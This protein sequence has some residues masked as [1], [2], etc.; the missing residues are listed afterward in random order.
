MRSI[1]VFALGAAA[2]V[3]GAALWSRPAVSAGPA[4]RPATRAAAPSAALAPR[5]S[6]PADLPACVDQLDAL[7]VQLAVL[8]KQLAA[9]GGARAEWPDDAPAAVRPEAVRAWLEEE[10]QGEPVSL[11]TLDCDEYPCVAV[12]RY[13]EGQPTSTEVI[14]PLHDAFEA[15]T[16]GRSP[17]ALYGAPHGAF[18]ILAATPRDLTAQAQERLTV[19]LREAGDQLTETP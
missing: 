12:F 19:R 5:L 14:G 3:L 10:M 18:A 11:E 4:S 1:L 13:A 9:Y 17:V 16:G 7:S 6:P 2:G 8:E 15:R